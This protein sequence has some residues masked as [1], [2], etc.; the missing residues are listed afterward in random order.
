MHTKGDAFRYKLMLAAVV[1]LALAVCGGGG[2]FGPGSPPPVPGSVLLSRGP[3]LQL[4]GTTSATI[5]WRTNTPV[6]TQIDYG[7]TSSLDATVRDTTPKTQHVVALTNLAAGTTY[8]YRL[9]G[10]AGP[11][12]TIESF[13]TSP[14]DERRFR[15]AVFGDSGTGSP[16]Q[17]SVADRIDISAPD[18]CLH[19]GDLVYPDGR[20]ELF[21]S[22][23]FAPYADIL[24]SAPLYPALGNHD[25]EADGGRSYLE[26]FY[27]PSNNPEGTER[28][29][30]FDYGNA[31]IAALDTN[32]S[33][34]P[35]SAQYAWLRSDLAQTTKR[36]KFVFLH[37]AP[38]S[39]SVHATDADVL[40]VRTALSPVFDEFNVDLVFGGHDHNYE[41]SFPLN[42][43]SVIDRNQEPAYTNPRGTVYIVTGGGGRDLYFSASSFFTAFSQSEFHFTLVEVNGSQLRLQAIAGDGRILDQ[44]TITKSP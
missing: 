20:A 42:A 25:L 27:L 6:A 32:R 18:F 34:A 5:V 22:R 31:H 11:L 28:Y 41:R 1:C 43:G 21:D 26:A 12:T 33:V 39:S 4:V 19:T 24:N 23:F 17:L 35:G 38:Y 8:F 14:L 36:W 13:Q 10:P 15:F 30:S 29:Y 2:S 7:P 16:A 37:H 3:Y 44:M 40:E 9:T